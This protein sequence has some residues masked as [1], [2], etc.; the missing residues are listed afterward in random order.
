MTLPSHR[1]A[2]TCVSEGQAQV[3]KHP[4][5]TTLP[6]DH[7]LIRVSHVALNPADWKLLDHKPSG[8]AILGLDLSG[9]VVATSDSLTRNLSVGDRVA[10]FSYG[11]NPYGYG[12]GAFTDYALARSGCC[13]NVGGE[14]WEK[15]GGL[16]AAS[17]VVIA[18]QTCGSALFHHLDLLKNKPDQILIYGGSTATGSIAIQLAKAAGLKVITTCSPKSNAFVKSRGAD[19]VF[20]YRSPT[21]G[22]DIN[23]YTENKLLYV[24]DCIAED[25]TACICAAAVSTAPPA[26]V[27]PK[28]NLLQGVFS[29]NPDAQ[30]RKDDVEWSL[31]WGY[32][33]F[34]VKYIEADGSE[35]EARPQDYERTSQ[36][37]EETMRLFKKG[38][39]VPHPHELRE[40]GLNGIMQG[41]QDMKD[42]KISG[43]KLVYKVE[44]EVK[45]DT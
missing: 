2:L 22:A 36:F 40:G 18:L 41:F 37:F 38:K 16:E 8:N 14:E 17:T 20:D 43:V 19:E 42:N 4:I 10:A 31:T 11:M 13:I 27:K 9:T 24:F 7:V 12:Q 32:R 15:L 29:E 23:R 25:D 35:S 26:G 44:G 5:P 33:N 1:L 28:I 6:D 21:V 34:G 45:G 3:K 30:P 39:L